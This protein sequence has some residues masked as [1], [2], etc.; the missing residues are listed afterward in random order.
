MKPPIPTPPPINEEREARIRHLRWNDFAAGAAVH[1]ALFAVERASGYQFTLHDHDFCEMMLVL[2]GT[3]SHPVNGARQTLTA[4][5]LTFLRPPDAH[6]V[7]VP[8]GGKLHWI[9]V[10][11]PADAWQDFCVAAHLSW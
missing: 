1:A 7:V 5:M 10:A 2:D 8:S 6:A 3:G 11:F 9:N 4:G